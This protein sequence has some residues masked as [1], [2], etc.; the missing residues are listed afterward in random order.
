MVPVRGCAAALQSWR[1]AFAALLQPER[2]YHRAED[3]T[4][5]RQAE[6]RRFVVQV[7]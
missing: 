2:G 7:L 5:P 6:W 4:D 3:Q 1:W